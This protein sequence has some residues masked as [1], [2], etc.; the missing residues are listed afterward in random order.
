M[1]IDEFQGSN[2][3]DTPE[4]PGIY[5]WYYRP[6][7][8][9]DHEAKTL[10]RLITSPSSVKTEIAMRYGLMWE[11]DSDVNVLHGGKQRR[12]PADKIVLEAV[13]SGGDLVE[14][15]FKSLMLP[16]FAKPLYIGRSKNLYQRVYKEHYVLLTELWELD[17]P[18]SKYLAGHPDATVKEVLEQL[19]LPHL[20]FAV[21]ARVKELRTGD[22][23]VC[24]CQIEIPDSQDRVGKIGA[25][26]STSS[27]SNLW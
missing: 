16:Y 19:N 6:H 4:L 12:Q 27:R 23:R 1:K 7:V 25:N 2:I 13:A 8:F 21:E 3:I 24:V 10:G 20:S 11:V 9:G 15:F 18:V 22:L 14:S 5:A 17:T 26:S